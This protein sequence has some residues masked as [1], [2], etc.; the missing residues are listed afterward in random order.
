MTA[1]ISAAS[2]PFSAACWRMMS[3]WRSGSV[4]SWIASSNCRQAERPGA[5]GDA[6]PATARRRRAGAAAVALLRFIPAASRPGRTAPARDPRREPSFSI[7][8]S[9]RAAFS[10]LGELARLALVDQGVAARLGALAAHLVG[11]DDR[12]GGVEDARPSPTRTAAAPR[13]RRPR[14][15]AGSEASQAPIR[16]PTSGWICD[17]SQV[18]LLGVGEDDLADPARS[19]APAGRDLLAPALDQAAAAA[20]RSRAARGRRRRWRSS[21]RPAA[22]RPPAPRTSRP[23]SRR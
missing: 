13:P 5:D 23:R 15:P 21:P 12:D 9:A 19:T 3:S 14:R 8:C 10:V 18:E 20:A 4:S 16:S 1:A 17:S 2:T 6:R 22:R 7:T 11:G